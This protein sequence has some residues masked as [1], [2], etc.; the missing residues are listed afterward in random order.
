MESR[1]SKKENLIV[2]LY[3]GSTAGRNTAV[4][5]P[6][7]KNIEMAKKKL[8]EWSIPIISEDTGGCYGRTIIFNTYTNEIVVKMLQNC[9]RNCF[10]GKACT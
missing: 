3:G 1:G 9:L 2:K 5:N 8:I 6:G 10:D 4:F 7:I